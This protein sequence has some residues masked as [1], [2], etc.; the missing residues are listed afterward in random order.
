MWKYSLDN[1]QTWTDLPSCTSE[2]GCKVLAMEEA[3]Q[4]EKTEVVISN[5]EY[6][7]TIYICGYCL[8]EIKNTEVLTKIETP[9]GQQNFHKH[10]D[11]ILY[12]D[13]AIFEDL[14]KPEKMT[15]EEFDQMYAEY[16]LYA[17]GKP[18]GS[19]IHI[20][21]RDLTLIDISNKYIHSA[22]FENCVFKASTIIH[23]MFEYCKFTNCRI[24]G[25]VLDESVFKECDFT[26]TIFNLADMVDAMFHRCDFNY[27]RILHSNLSQC[28]FV[29]SNIST[30]I[31]EENQG[32]K[33][34]TEFINKN[35]E[36]SREGCIGYII[37][38]EWCTNTLITDGELLTNTFLAD[39]TANENASCRVYPQTMLKDLELYEDLIWKVA[40]P[41]EYL[42]DVCVPSFNAK[43]LR[44][45][46][47]KV[48]DKLI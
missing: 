40:I 14:D 20:E 22:V 25:T 17:D 27:G 2:N 24:S 37:E 21:D 34:A 35:Y 3:Y 11:K 32:I 9:S 29:E 46:F 23:S 8:E 15:Q 30:L 5:G 36:K 28:E 44:S 33:S 39:T 4:R 38:S 42:A 13:L 10:C 47:V 19:L 26:N 18:G 45:R 1:K 43:F 41:Y 31:Q 6:E 7:E 12:W 16:R 48:L